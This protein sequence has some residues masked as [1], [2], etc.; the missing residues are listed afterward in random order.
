MRPNYKALEEARQKLVDEGLFIDKSKSKFKRGKVQKGKVGVTE[1]SGVQKRSASTAQAGR[2]DKRTARK[3]SKKKQTAS[4]GDAEHTGKAAGKKRPGPA[5]RRA[6]KEAAAAKKAAGDDS[7]MDSGAHKSTENAVSNGKPAQG[8]PKNTEYDGAGSKKG[9]TGRK[10]LHVMT[11]DEKAKARAAS[12]AGA[13][14]K[15]I[16]L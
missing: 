9:S 5:L 13:T 11:D 7:V 15:R 3:S 12:Y 16:T 1:S 4:A 6:M 10:T 2:T 8:Q 14:R